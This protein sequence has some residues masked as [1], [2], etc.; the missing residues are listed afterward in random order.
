MLPTAPFLCPKTLKA[1]VAIS[2]YIGLVSSL[3]LHVIDYLRWIFSLLNL[4]FFPCTH[5]LE[6][7]LIEK[8]WLMWTELMVKL[9]STLETLGVKS[10]IQEGCWEVLF[11]AVGCRDVQKW[12]QVTIH[13]FKHL[14]YIVQLC[15]SSWT[16]MYS[17]LPSITNRSSS[18]L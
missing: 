9:D 1:L 3:Y 12:L 8:L 18:C 6:H 16:R 17:S 11:N 7:N 15:G 5:T 14:L 2:R 10:N 13:K 4:C